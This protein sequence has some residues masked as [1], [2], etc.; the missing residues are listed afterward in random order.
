M[1]SNV[2]R[3]LNTVEFH[4]LSGKKYSEYAYVRVLGWSLSTVSHG[5]RS[6]FFLIQKAAVFST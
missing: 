1:I 4:F 5:A 6:T 2:Q 3:S